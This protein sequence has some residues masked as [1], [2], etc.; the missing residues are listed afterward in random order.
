MRYRQDIPAEQLARHASD[1]ML[2]FT[3]VLSL[4]IGA[5]LIWLGRKGKQQWLVLWSIGLILSSLGMGTYLLMDRFN[6]LPA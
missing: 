3:A 5:V 4:F 1:D 2:I 6:L